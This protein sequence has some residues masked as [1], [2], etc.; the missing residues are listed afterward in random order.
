[1]REFAAAFPELGR[2]V[3]QRMED[4]IESFIATKQPGQV[5]APELQRVKGLIRRS[6]ATSGGALLG[7]ARREHPFHGPAIL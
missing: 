6:E 1:M 5:D 2:E 7:G 4:G 3:A